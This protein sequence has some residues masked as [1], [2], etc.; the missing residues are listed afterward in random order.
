MVERI[1]I[2][3]LGLKGLIFTCCHLVELCFIFWEFSPKNNSGK[4]LKYLTDSFSCC[5]DGKFVKTKGH[6]HD[7]IIWLKVPQLALRQAIVFSIFSFHEESLMRDTDLQNKDCS[8]IHSGSHS[9]IMSSCKCSYYNFENKSVK[10]SS[11]RLNLKLLKEPYSFQEGLLPFWHPV[12]NCKMFQCNISIC[13]P[14]SVTSGTWYLVI[15]YGQT[16]ITPSSNDLV[17]GIEAS[18]N[19]LHSK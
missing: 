5:N 7:D 11:C 6:L 1:C 9:Q 2:M 15:Y 10:I 16:F 14:F 13:V 8:E 4:S 18:W 17:Q 19:P 12:Q 3:S